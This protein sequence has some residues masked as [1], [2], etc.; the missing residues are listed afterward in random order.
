[1]QV[2]SAEIKGNS[3]EKNR[4]KEKSEGDKQLEEIPEEVKNY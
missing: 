2:V 3:K 4:K 1:M